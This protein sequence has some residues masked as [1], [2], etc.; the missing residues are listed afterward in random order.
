MG[1]QLKGLLEI[2]HKVEGEGGQATLSVTTHGGKTKL[3]LEIQSSPS[4]TAPTS[5]PPTSGRRRRRQRG[6]AAR[7]LAKQRAA[8]HQATLVE[9]ATSDPLVSSPPSSTHSP[10][11]T[12][13]RRPLEHLLSPSPSSG[14]RRVMSLGR[15]AEMPSF[16]CLNLDGH[17]SSP[18]VEDNSSPSPPTR[19]APTSCPP[20]PFS[21]SC[22]GRV[23]PITGDEHHLCM[24][25]SDPDSGACWETTCDRC[26]EVLSSYFFNA[27]KC[28]V[29]CGEHHCHK[30][31]PGV[32]N[33][34]S[35]K[36]TGCDLGL[37]CCPCCHCRAYPCPVDD[38]LKKRIP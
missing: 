30:Q 4:G 22:T 20:L 12:A 19:P 17:C 26:G 2:F 34:W 13:P 1:D 25:S 21:Q 27:E 37:P 5:S 10:L 16:A 33:V 24:C 9:A 23:P 28:K 8:A 11:T 14:R 38:A 32:D 18:P 15:P 36:D 6:A 7:A 35:F 31:L 3:K 29:N